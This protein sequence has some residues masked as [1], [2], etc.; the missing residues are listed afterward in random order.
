M[1][2]EYKKGETQAGEK[3]VI[4][5]EEGRVVKTGIIKLHVST[6]D[7]RG[8][9][10]GQGKPMAQNG[11]FKYVR[12][13]IVQMMD[14]NQDMYLEET[15]K[16][17]NLMQEFKD[18]SVAIV[19]FPEDIYTDDSTPAG[20]VHA[21]GD[22]TFVTIVQRVLDIVGIR[23]H[24]GHPDMVRG[25]SFRQLGLFSAPWVNEDIFGAYKATLYGEKVISREI[26][27]AAK[28]REGVYIGLHGI[29]DK[30]GAGAGEQ[31][32]TNIL[33]M[34]NNSEVIGFARS[35][36][37]LVA[38]IG[39]FLRK[40]LVVLAN[41]TYIFTIILFGMSMFVS[42]PSELIAGLIGLFLSQAITMTG[43]IQTVLEIGLIKGTVKFLRLFPSL[44]VSYMA[45]VYNAFSVGVK[46]SMRNAAGYVKTGRRAGREHMT[47]FK[48][49][50][51]VTDVLNKGD[52]YA[53][54]NFAGYFW[55]IP[56]V[57][58][59][60]SGLILWASPG[61]V[62]S[63]FPIMMIVLA[64][65]APF[66]LNPGSTP[67]TVGWKT[68]WKVHFKIKEDKGDFWKFFK[69]IGPVKWLATT[70]VLAGIGILVGG[71]PFYMLLGFVV[72]YPFLGMQWSNAL[73]DRLLNGVL[74][75]VTKGKMIK[76]ATRDF[77]DYVNLYISGTFVMTAVTLLGVVVGLTINLPSWLGIKIKLFFVQVFDKK[78]AWMAKSA[79]IIGT[80]L[81]ALERSLWLGG[82]GAVIW[83]MATYLLPVLGILPGYGQF[84]VF[85]ALLIFAG[86][87][88]AGLFFGN[89]QTVNNSLEVRG[90]LSNEAKKDIKTFE[91]DSKT[92]I[93]ELLIPTAKWLL[94]TKGNIDDFRS[95]RR[96]IEKLKKA[97]DNGI[98]DM[99]KK[100]VPDGDLGTAKKKAEENVDQRKIEYIRDLWGKIPEDL[101]KALEDSHNNDAGKSKLALFKAMDSLSEEWQK[102]VIVHL[103]EQT[104]RKIISKD[105]IV[106][107]LREKWWI[108]EEIWDSTPGELRDALLYVAKENINEAH[109]ALSKEIK[110]LF[111]KRQKEEVV[112]RLLP[113]AAREIIS[114]GINRKELDNIWVRISDEL[115]QALKDVNG[116]DINEAKTM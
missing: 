20:A 78:E 60:F 109:E 86:S 19:G 59:A 108:T 48:P 116:G 90:K 37:H 12:G 23:Y 30:F 36:M 52:L 79:D 16:G 99:K 106:K 112:D 70:G 115:R 29:S 11:I 92:V 21:F 17:P 14:M 45:L 44:A 114:K 84:L 15:F 43:Y 102:Y 3:V 105:K 64:M 62:W 96:E 107:G 25:R 51:G 101:R 49:M 7:P 65:L 13:E 80:I 57:L 95:Q 6:M 40:P 68:W 77:R 83:A 61:A 89:E 41:T 55:V 10:V 75:R 9:P 34:H 18:N 54:V 74:G 82:M 24:Y 76:D 4:E 42:F 32:I 67:A 111:Q 53:Q 35:F 66:L 98:E 2:F 31:A 85:A 93:A 28:G 63:F 56:A 97:L 8:G 94:L 46:K 27:Q 69:K 81:G 5:L 58:M 71:F 72:L 100:R 38:S 33:R 1:R 73:I 104:A 26:M 103:L 87:F 50:D 110:K 91:S 47:P 113:L 88:F 22:H 39:Y